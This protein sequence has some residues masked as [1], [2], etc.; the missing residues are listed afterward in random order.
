MCLQRKE[1]YLSGHD[2]DKAA[3]PDLPVPQSDAAQSAPVF[4][5]EFYRE[6]VYPAFVVPDVLH[7]T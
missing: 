1:L 3:R 5:L 2:A 7:E 4:R 6:S